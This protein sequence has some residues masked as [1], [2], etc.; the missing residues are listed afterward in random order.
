MHSVRIIHCADIHMGMD[1]SGAR[2]KSRARKAEV[3]KTFLDIIDRCQHNDADLLLIAGDLFDGANVGAEDMDDIIEA[4]NGLTH[5]RV[6]IAPGN[7][8]YI[9][10]SSMYIQKKWPDN[11]HIFTGGFEIVEI[12]ELGVRV[13]G[14]GFTS[15]YVRVG[16]LTGNTMPA[17][18]L[19]N[20]GVLHGE[21]VGRGAGSDYNPI[22]DRDIELSGMDYLALGHIHKQ[23]S[24]SL[25]GGTYYSY[26]GCPE[27]HG[28][29]E[30]GIKGIYEGTIAR[31][32]CQL[33]YVR[34][35]K[36]TYE[37][38]RADISGL[39]G[40]S[41]ITGRIISLMEQQC[42][43]GY[44]DNMYKLVLAGEIKADCYFNIN[45]IKARLD[46]VYYVKLRDDTTVHVD[47]ADIA[48]DASLKGVFAAGM[49][50]QINS[51][52]QSGDTAKAEL[53]RKALGVGLKAFM[54]EV[55]YNED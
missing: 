7:H 55:G 47:M 46:N 48:K 13:G 19:I 30:T 29:D 15:Q 26:C 53:Y 50:D 20:I 49:L 12:P 32:S 10:P 40:T 8:D 23:S 35:C 11:T 39:E 14:A 51:L 36:R 6:F 27:G 5:T 9:N 25:K 16:M 3:K 34:M 52:E 33:E 41:A 37:T 38:I 22:T 54:G 28:F 21:L 24:I 43:E 18:E 44:E 45:D 4:I 31:G 17:D 42:S 2:I 1:F